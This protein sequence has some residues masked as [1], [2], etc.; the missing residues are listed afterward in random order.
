MNYSVT[1]SFDIVELAVSEFFSVKVSDIY[2]RDRKRNTSNA[3]AFVWFVLHYNYGISSNN[4]AKKYGR[5]RRNVFLQLS[6]IKF[7]VENQPQEHDD[8]QKLLEVV[9]RVEG[10]KRLI[11]TS[12][13]LR[14]PERN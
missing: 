1:S 14:E 11:E 5:T 13:P 3:R 10:E 6:G 7:L 4:I 12:S 9:K 8:Y 2:S